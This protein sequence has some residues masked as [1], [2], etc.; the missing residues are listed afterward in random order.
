MIDPNTLFVAGMP[1]SMLVI[2]FIIFILILYWDMKQE[3]KIRKEFEE[4]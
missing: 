2:G 4:L 3:D 1:L